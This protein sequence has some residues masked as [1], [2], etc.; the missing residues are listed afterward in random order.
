MLVE[1]FS[2]VFRAEETSPA[3]G[4]RVNVSGFVGHAVS[5]T[6]AQLCGQCDHIRAAPEDDD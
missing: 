3:K 1:D 5:V 6:T 4:Q 2:W